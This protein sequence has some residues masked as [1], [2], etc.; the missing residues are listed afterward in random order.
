MKFCCLVGLIFR[1]SSRAWMEATEWEHEHIPQIRE[2]IS[3]MSSTFLPTTRASKNRAPSDAFRWQASTLFLLIFRSR[4]AWP[5]ILQMW[6]R[7]ISFILA[8][9]IPHIFFCIFLALL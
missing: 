8:F 1:A 3:W 7:F 9:L 4:E 6:F 2:T 5:S